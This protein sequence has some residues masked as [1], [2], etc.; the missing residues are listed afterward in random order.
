MSPME[1]KKMPLK[2][3]RYGSYEKSDYT[4]KSNIVPNP[5]KKEIPL[6]AIGY[7]TL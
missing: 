3:T 5:M 4:N 7:E 6:R 1:L 2:E